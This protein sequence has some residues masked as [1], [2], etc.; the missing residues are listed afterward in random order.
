[1]RIKIKPNRGEHFSILCDDELN[2]EFSIRIASIHMDFYPPYIYE[3]DG[4]DSVASNIYH[5][6]DN[7]SYVE[8][9]NKVLSKKDF[10]SDDDLKKIEEIKKIVKTLKWKEK[11]RIEEIIDETDNC[12]WSGLEWLEVPFDYNKFKEANINIEE[13]IGS[14]DSYIKQYG[15]GLII[16]LYNKTINEWIGEAKS[17]NWKDDFF[18]D[19]GKKLNKIAEIMDRLDYELGNLIKIT[20]KENLPDLFSLLYM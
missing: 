18:G 3:Y 2:N 15:K 13:V 8:K 5:F 16:Y 10:L 1:M 11:Y 14:L 7:I 4:T 17:G 12:N 6:E 19:N 20:I 9:M